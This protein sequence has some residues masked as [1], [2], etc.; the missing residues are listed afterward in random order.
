M[1][2]VAFH[3]F[4]CRFNSLV[5]AWQVRLVLKGNRILRVALPE[6]RSGSIDQT[7]VGAVWWT[8]SDTGAYPRSQPTG[9]FPN[10]EVVES[11]TPQFIFVVPHGATDDDSVPHPVTI[12]MN[13]IS[14]PFRVGEFSPFRPSEGRR[15][16][17][18]TLGCQIEPLRGS[19]MASPI[20]WLGQHFHSI[21]DHAERPAA[22]FVWLDHL[23]GSQFNFYDMV[24]NSRS[25]DGS[26]QDCRVVG[27]DFGQQ[28]SKGGI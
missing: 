16:Y 14:N 20:T 11:A 17:T 27:T 7:W 23:L 18:P 8:P 3:R 22:N 12:L 13:V 2:S 5:P 24:K 4:R 21:K 25:A 9:N 10:H 19:A 6:P 28:A 15:E 1:H 26:R